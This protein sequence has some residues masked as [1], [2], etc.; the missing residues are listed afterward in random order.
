MEPQSPRAADGSYS[1]QSL[2]VHAS[3]VCSGKPRI[4]DDNDDN[5]DNEDLWFGLRRVGLSL[6]NGRDLLR[7]ILQ[8]AE[9][10]ITIT[11]GITG[12]QSGGRLFLSFLATDVCV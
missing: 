7:D 3:D 6:N 4:Q 8:D 5:N 11:F 9:D 2:T 1:P 10:V 12:G